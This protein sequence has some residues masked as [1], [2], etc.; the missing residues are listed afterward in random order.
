MELPSYLINSYTDFV[1]IRF[2]RIRPQW[3]GSSELEIFFMALRPKAG[4]V[5]LILKVSRSPATTHQRR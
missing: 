1:E 5:L 3:V 2:G 4:Y